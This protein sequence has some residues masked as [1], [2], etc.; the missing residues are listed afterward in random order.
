MADKDSQ[1]HNLPY[2]VASYDINKE[3]LQNQPRWSVGPGDAP[4]A[5]KTNWLS[6]YQYQSITEDSL[7]RW[8]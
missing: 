4:I 3:A 1:M 6:S 8:N 2:W 7:L 5:V